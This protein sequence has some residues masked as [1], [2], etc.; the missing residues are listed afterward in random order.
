MDDYSGCIPLCVFTS[1]NA[2]FSNEVELFDKLFICL[3]LFTFLVQTSH[4][5]LLIYILVKLPSQISGCVFIVLSIFM[6]LR[7]KSELSSKY[8][9]FIFYQWNLETISSRL[10]VRKA[11]YARIE[12]K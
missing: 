5:K 3:V 11:V 9:N 1:V 7:R 12:F 8:S 2:K 4:V 10:A 6:I